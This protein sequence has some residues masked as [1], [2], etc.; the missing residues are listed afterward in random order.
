MPARWSLRSTLVAIAALTLL[1]IL[2]LA[3]WQ[4]EREQAARV[5]LREASLAA[6]ADLVGAR[7]GELI[8]ASRRL[9]SAACMA[10]VVRQS[11]NNQPEP[12]DVSRCESYFTRV[13]STAPSQ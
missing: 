13:L 2:G 3:A 9:L 4:A 11:A 12:V 5:A 8:E 10:D 7:Y 6:A 1:P